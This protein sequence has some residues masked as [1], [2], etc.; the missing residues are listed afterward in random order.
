MG[1]RKLIATCLQ[2]ETA[3]AAIA[4][5]NKTFP[6]SV[7]SVVSEIKTNALD[8][9]CDLEKIRFDLNSYANNYN[10]AVTESQAIQ[11]LLLASNLFKCIVF[12]VTE[13][14]EDDGTV[15]RVRVDFT[16]TL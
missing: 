3:Y 15:H 16:L 6:Y 2:N 10:Q 14:V 13:S 12:S 4:P 1:L 7:W 8:K 9:Q 5:Q 11:A